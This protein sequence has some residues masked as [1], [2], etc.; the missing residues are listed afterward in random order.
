MSRG[1]RCAN[2]DHRHCWKSFD[3]DGPI[4]CFLCRQDGGQA[5]RCSR[6]TNSGTNC[7]STPPGRLRIDNKLTENAIRS[8]VTGRKAWLFSN[9][10]AGANARTNRYRQVKTAAANGLKLHAFLKMVMT[11]LMRPFVI[12]KVRGSAIQMKTRVAC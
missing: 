11:E 9:S 1:C 2:P 4:M 7:R 3:S 6:S 10:V 8:F 12:C 5:K